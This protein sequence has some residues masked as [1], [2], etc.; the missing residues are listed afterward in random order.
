MSAL[1]Q[2]EIDGV[3]LHIKG[4]IFA[5]ALLEQRGASESELA[6]HAAELQR[7]RRRLAELVRGRSEGHPAEGESFPGVTLG[8]LASR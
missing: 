2:D 8:E 7:E 5:R 1:D 3:L 6:E 4:L